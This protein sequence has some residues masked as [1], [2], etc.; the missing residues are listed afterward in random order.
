MGF[1]QI[2]ECTQEHEQEIANQV[3]QIEELAQESATLSAEL[4]QANHAVKTLQGEL[5]QCNRE[6][7][8]LAIRND[9]R[10]ADLES[11]LL[12][13]SPDQIKEIKMMIRQYT[14]QMA[15]CYQIYQ[16]EEPTYW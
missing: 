3:K 15:L 11:S 16:S 13:S 12:T 6:L 2:A 8:S 10:C 14:K 1:E 7:I 4:K 9:N 5:A